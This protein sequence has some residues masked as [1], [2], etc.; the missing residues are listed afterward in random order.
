MP[1]LKDKISA[2][3]NGVKP[4][5]MA[6]IGQDDP[7]RGDSKG[8]VGVGRAVAK[9]VGGDYV[10]VD[11]Q[12]LS[13][14]F[15]KVSAYRDQLKLYIESVGNPDI[16]IG[17][18]MG[19]MREFVT[20]PITLSE[21]RYNEGYSHER[22]TESCGLV[23]HDLSDGFLNAAGRCFA[24]HNVEH[25][26]DIHG[27]LIGVLM[28]GAYSQMD[29]V[30]KSMVDMAQH[31]SE[32]TFY[33]CPSRRTGTFHFKV[34]KREIEIAAIGKRTNIRIIGESYA[35]QMHSYNPYH[36]LLAKADHLVIVGDSGSIVSEALFAK[37]RIYVTDPPP[38]LQPLIDKGH[39]TDLFSVSEQ[40]FLNVKMPRVNVTMEVATSIAQEYMIACDEKVKRKAD[41]QEL[42]RCL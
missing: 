8:A 5:V 3:N 14:K 10:Y 7:R 33:L 25:N 15:N 13:S 26:T 17:P 23:A 39:I 28:G 34:L 11:E 21:E 41:L 29:A 12:R 42:V 32:A 16:V 18:S 2:Y 1:D 9:M 27:P 24:D 4:L 38:I 37:K 20:E 35:K 40:P 6:F 36:G 19:F 31:M 30:A 22:S